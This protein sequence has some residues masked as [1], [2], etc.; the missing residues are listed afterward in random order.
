LI[1]KDPIRQ[2]AEID[3]TLALK[4]QYV[5]SSVVPSAE[6]S[7]RALFKRQ[8]DTLGRRITV[9]DITRAAMVEGVDYVVVNRCNL[10]GQ[11]DSV[12]DLVP[13]DDTYYLEVFAVILNA[14]YSEREI[15]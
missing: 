3:V 6:A 11:P 15:Y 8:S 2:F 13:I 10:S 5:V 7:I 4:T 1:P 12:S 9:S 14:K